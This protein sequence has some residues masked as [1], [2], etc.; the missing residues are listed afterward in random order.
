MTCFFFNEKAFSRG[1]CVI[2][3]TPRNE[4]SG[5]ISGDTTAF[6]RGKCVYELSH[7]GESS[8]EIQPK[9]VDISVPVDNLIIRL[10]KN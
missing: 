7:K 6:S 9:L 10:Q 5:Y 2:E 4:G 8:H 3:L 1:K